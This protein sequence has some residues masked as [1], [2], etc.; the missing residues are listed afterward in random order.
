M[1]ISLYI[2][3]IALCLSLLAGNVRAEYVPGEVLVKFKDQSRN[4]TITSLHFNIG[5]I[6]K[7]IIKELN[8]H[9]VKLTETMTVEEAIQYYEQDPNVEYAE[10]NYIFHVAAAPDDPDFS[11]QWGLHNLSTD[12]DIDA[13]EAWDE[14]TGSTDVVIAVVDTGLA[15]LHPDFYDPLNSANTNIWVNTGEDYP[16]CNDNTDNDNNG[17]TDDCYGWD[18]LN[19]DNDPTDYNYDGTLGLDGHGTHVAGTIAAYGNNGTGISGVMW[20]ARIMPLRFLGIDGSGDAADAAEAILYASKNGAHVI[21]NSWAGSGFS[22]TLKNA[23][24]SS[25][26]VVVCAAGNEHSNNDTLPSYPS[27]FSSSNIISVAATNQSD[28]LASFSNYGKTSVD[29]AA[30]GVSVLSIVPDVVASTEVTEYT[31][32][33]EGPFTDL[34]TFGWDRGGTGSSW[35][36]TS[37][38]GESGGNTLEDSPGADYSSNITSWAGYMTPITSD[39]NNIYTLSLR[40][41]YSLNSSDV[42]YMLY[43]LNGTDWISLDS[44]TGTSSGFTTT[45]STGLTFIAEKYSDFRFGV[46]IATNSTGTDDGVYIDEVTLT[47]KP[48]TINSYTYKSFSGTSMATPHVSGVAGLILAKY[49]SLSSCQVI[50]MILNGVDPLSSLSNEVATGGR[51][52]AYGAL[53]A[54]QD[55]SACSTVSSSSTS[56]GGGGGGCF[57]DTAAYGSVVRPYI[58]KLW[59]VTDQIIWTRSIYSFTE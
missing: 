40:W 10:P 26:A 37:A 4:S 12:I 18:F 25:N 29:L 1:R 32:D 46:G 5:S 3:A 36:V 53:V 6:K 2:T 44:F 54:A 31:E 30:P 52:N 58:E 35:D 24:D 49:P 51:L 16:D 17:Y 28:N 27:N 48:L 41:S 22:Q 45:S 9:R 55:S 19:D 59:D 43:S 38:T 13:P 7:K 8:V 39:K 20:R 11:S 23:I 57:I 56:S 50:N 21:N 33:F 15:R 47:K 34:T 14:T 42:L